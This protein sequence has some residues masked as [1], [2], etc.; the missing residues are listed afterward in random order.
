LRKIL[1]SFGI[2]VS[3]PVVVEAGFGTLVLAL[4][5]EE[6]GGRKLGLDTTLPVTAE[7]GCLS[8]VPLPIM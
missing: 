3:K 7:F 6:A 2:I 8:H 5:V 1:P 4:I